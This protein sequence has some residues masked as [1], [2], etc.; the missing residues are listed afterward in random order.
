MKT[1]RGLK[2]VFAQSR[3]AGRIVVCDGRE[4]ERLSRYYIALRNVIE[5]KDYRS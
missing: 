4:L 1:M 3:S 5:V 2:I